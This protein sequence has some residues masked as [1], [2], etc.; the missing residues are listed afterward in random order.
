MIAM[1][2][3]SVI[4]T[5]R[6]SYSR[7]KSALKYSDQDKLVTFGI[8]PNTPHTGYG[9][10]ESEN[11]LVKNKFKGERIIRFIEKKV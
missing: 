8:S 3:V 5:A 2:K 9:Y 11:A 7:I 6:P 1:R 4:I 10:I